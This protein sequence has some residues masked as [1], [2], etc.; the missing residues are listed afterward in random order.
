MIASYNYMLSREETR[1]PPV[2]K[3]HAIA[4]GDERDFVLFRV[5][6]D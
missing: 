6:V 1:L 3:G 4:Q 5:T 2:M